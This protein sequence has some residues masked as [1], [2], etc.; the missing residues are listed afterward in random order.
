MNS[1]EIKTTVSR[2]RI[3]DMLVG[4]LEGGSNYWYWLPNSEADKAR[5]LHG[6]IDGTPLADKLLNY[7]WETDN[8]IIITDIEE[9]DPEDVSNSLGEF[10]FANIL[11]GTQLMQKDYPEHFADMVNES[12][13]GTTSDV[14]FQLVVLGKL[15]YG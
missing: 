7:V 6:V 2:E 10:S 3:L 15:V 8:K 12:D 5:E 11:R 14:W 1:I 4:A 9:D 13:D